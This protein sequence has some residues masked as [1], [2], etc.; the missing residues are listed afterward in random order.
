VITSGAQQAINLTTQILID[1][2]DVVLVEEPT[3]IGALGVF[4]NAFAEIVPVP[5]DERGIIPSALAAI[6]EEQQKKGKVIKMLYTIPNFQNPSGIS[7]AVTRRPDVLHLAKY[8]DFLILEDDAYGELGFDLQQQLTEPLKA[9]DQEGRVIYTGSFSKILSPGMRLGWVIAP[10]PLIERLEMAR[11]MSDVCPNPL[12]QALVNQLCQENYFADHIPFLRK[13]YQGRCN[14]MLKALTAYMPADILWT[15][16]QG[17]FYVWLTFP[18]TVDTLKMLPQAVEK[19]VAYVI[20]SAFSA[21]G[22]LKNS[23]RLSF[24]RETET[25]IE[26]GIR[27]L[28]ET[29][30]NR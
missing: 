3:F 10:E 27:R 13:Q 8:Y 7:L 15:E 28:A 22:K 9:L 2:G 12:T 1:P 30:K 6:C 5:L 24:S 16:P 26:E 19:K 23:L 17:G 21:S 4:R 25:V 11:Q 29:I 14:A 18:D 20:G